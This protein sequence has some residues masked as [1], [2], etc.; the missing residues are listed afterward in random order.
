KHSHAE[1]RVLAHEQRR[2]RDRA[3]ALAQAIRKLTYRVTHLPGARRADRRTQ[4]RLDAV[5]RTHPVGPR[6]VARLIGPPPA[7]IV[8][9]R[10]VPGHRLDGDRALRPP[11]P[12]AP[13]YPVEQGMGPLG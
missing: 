6:D 11:P 2:S 13:Q 5:R 3:T 12:P 1:H 8:R 10:D 9:R 4:G 7:T